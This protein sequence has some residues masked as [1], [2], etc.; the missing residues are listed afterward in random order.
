MLGKIRVL[1]VDDHPMIRDAIKLYFA[2]H[3]QISI[4]GEA[5]NGKDALA[6]L[7]KRQFDVV[8]TDIAMPE[9]D[10]AELLKAMKEKGHEEAVLI[11]SMINEASQIKRMIAMG[12]MGYVP[13]NS[14]KEDIRDGIVAISHGESYYSKDVV[15]IL[16]GQISG[17]KP[18]Q[19]LTL[20]VPLTRREKEITQ[21]IMQELGNQEIADK[22][23][24]SVRTVEAHKRNILEKTGCKSLAGLAIYAMEKG[25]I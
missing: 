14:P 4:E 8:V 10:G 12:A 20:E 21:L 25:I 11:I 3:D 22:L 2:D 24:I 5:D 18:I 16:M 15:D 19:R 23:F 17:R 13:K 1:L 6:L 9:M 7:A